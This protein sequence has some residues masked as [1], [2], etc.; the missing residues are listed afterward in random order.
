MSMRP[1]DQRPSGIAPAG[2]LPWGTHFCVLYTSPEEL[3]QVL[4]PFVTAGLRANE[5]CCWQI[6]PPLSVEAMRTASATALPDLER[7]VALGQ[8]ELIS[9]D[10]DPEFATP[11]GIE[12]RIDRAILAGFDGVRIVCPALARVRTDVLETIGRL[13]VIGAFLYPRAEVSAVGLMQVVQQHHFALLRNSDRWEMLEGSEARSAREALARTEEKLQSLFGNMSEGFAYHRIVL[14]RD[15]TPCDYLFLDANP[16]FER[17]TGFAI[18]AIRGKR[19]SEVLPGITSDPTDWI[20]KYGRVALTGQP[21]QFESYAAPLDRW[22]FV[23]AF[24]PHKGYF[25]VTFADITERRRGEAE[26]RRVEA[27]LRESEQRFRLALRNAP[28]SVAAQDRDL[29]YVW[30]YNQR[31]TAP[32]EVVGKCDT[33]LFTA[34]EA[35]HLAAIKR[36]VLD[37]NIEL[38][39]QMWVTR[40]GGRS[41]F[42]TCF[43]PI[44]DE[45]GNTIGVGTATVDLTPMKAVE[46]ELER[47]V[48]RER[49]ARQEAELANRTKDD[50]LASVSH[51]LRSP[52]NAILGWAVLLRSDRPL[53]DA[54]RQRALE[55][56]ERGARAQRQLIEDLLDLARIS[57]GKLRLEVQRVELLPVIEAAVDA[58][59]PMVEAKQ[60]QL[61]VIADPNAAPV[62]G[63]SDRLQQILWN[64][65]S[66]AIK[67]TDKQGRV[68]VRLERVNSHVEIIVSDSGVEIDPEFLPHV[69][70][71]FRQGDTRRRAGGLG[72][73]LAITRQLVEL[74]GGTVTAESQ[75]VGQGATFIV[76][77]PLRPVQT[78]TSVTPAPGGTTMSLANA[79]ALSGVRVLAVDDEPESRSVLRAILEAAG[80]E[81]RVVSSAKEALDALSS[82]CWDVLVSD[83]EMPDC[84]GYAL[85]G[86][87]RQLQLVQGTSMPA[88][89]LT[90][91]ARMQDRVR[92]ITA[93]FDIHVAKPVEPEELLAV[94]ASLAARVVR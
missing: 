55:A 82:E 12:K 90:A 16:A 69:F 40:P 78:E 58:V 94:I 31:T 18:G 57:S 62:S 61:R 68:Q 91:Y 89:A 88:V 9:S 49:E 87:V 43:E 80:A 72:L 36:R 24:S 93:G 51:E 84:D 70:E 34:E 6:A 8:L 26:R 5:L 73:G 33:D 83:I 56:I 35:A 3:V 17:L 32:E 27:V 41:F 71:R 1:L 2:A 21:L 64:L 4:V 65:L 19:V 86:Q 7:H 66:N 46:D 13:N 15:G 74:H 60:I 75:G 29:R 59:R 20:G 30:A 44:R 79:P 39:E 47:A 14:A 85:I 23:S 10:A 77:L 67:F 28:V 48:A 22:Y 53:D 45:S 81:T 25:A 63:D 42:D 38:R 37:D 52:L 76:R 92:A 54:T 50:F 11:A